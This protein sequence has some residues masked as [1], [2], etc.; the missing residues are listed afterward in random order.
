[1]LI[2]TGVV[3]GGGRESR[4]LVVGEPLAS[5]PPPPVCEASEKRVLPLLGV[6]LD[7]AGF[8]H[9]PTCTCIPGSVRFL[10]LERREL[11]CA[12]PQAS[13]VFGQGTKQVQTYT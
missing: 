8:L 12:I 6:R 3:G 13:R 5:S 10:P 2:V 7:A 4:S 11:A 9:V 1:M